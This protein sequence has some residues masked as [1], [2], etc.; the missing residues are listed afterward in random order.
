M[1]FRRKI[2]I[3]PSNIGY[4]YKKNKQVDKLTPGIYKRWDW[5]NNLDYVCIPTTSRLLSVVNQE[6]LTK[7]NIA[8]RFSYVIQYS[9]ADA[10][11]FITKFDILARNFDAFSWADT[12]VHELSQVQIRKEIAQLNAEEVNEKRSELMN[13]VPE[14]LSKE[15]EKYG[16][17]I[18]MELLKDITFPKMIQDLFAKQL[19]AKIRSKAD[20]E[21]ARTAVATARALKNASTLME[22]DANIKFIQ[23][24]ET[25][26]KIAASGKHTFMIGDSLINPEKDK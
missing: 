4:L 11:K 26:T 14:D 24:L 8:F 13:V 21:N 15:L 2:S 22:N 6:V 10:D 1:C 5:L 23:F 9:I 16:I 20:L 12:V 17:I 7:D 19:E 25:I 3:R 18:E